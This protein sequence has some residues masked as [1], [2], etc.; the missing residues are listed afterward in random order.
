MT[1]D[2]Y[3][4]LEFFYTRN[5]IQEQSLKNYLNGALPDD[6]ENKQQY[7]AS[8]FSKFKEMNFIDLAPDT[9]TVY[10]ITAVGKEKYEELSER[11]EINRRLEHLSAGRSG[12]FRF[13]TRF[14]ITLVIVVV[15]ISV[16]TSILLNHWSNLTNIF[17]NIMK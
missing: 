1:D 4:F 13:D 5:S 17:K 9:S 8:L 2:E 7:I 16:L 6:M 14:W 10:Q 11:K 12:I 3:K 15:V